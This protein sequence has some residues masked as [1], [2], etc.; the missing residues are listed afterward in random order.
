VKLPTFS[1]HSQIKE[2]EE[3]TRYAFTK[4][5]EELDEHLDS[6]N[7]NTGEIQL[8]QESVQSLEKRMDKL[9]EKFEEILSTLGH[10]KSYVVQPLTLREQEVFIALYTTTEYKECTYRIIS[11]KTGLPIKMI[12]ELIEI[13]IEKGVPIRRIEKNSEYYLD[14]DEDF[15][16]EQAKSNLLNL[17]KEMIRHISSVN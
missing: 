7:Q 5:K 4:V 14:L 11:Y 16:Q 9:E 15:K 13:L 1:N 8:T 10:K 12:E 17:N 6:I 3:S 2:I